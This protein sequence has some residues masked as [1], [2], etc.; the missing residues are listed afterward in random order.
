MCKAPCRCRSHRPRRAAS[1]AGSRPPR[2]R[3]HRPVCQGQHGAQGLQPLGPD[4]VAG[5]KLQPVA[6][7]FSAAKASVG[8][9]TPGQLSRPIRRVSP[10]S[11]GSH[12]RRDDDSAAGIGH[13]AQLFHGQNRACPDQGLCAKG[14]DQCRD[15][16]QRV[17]RV[18]RHLDG[19]DTC[20]DQSLGDGKRVFRGDPAQNGDDGS[21]HSAA[22][23]SGP[24]ARARPAM[25]QAV[26]GR[27]RALAPWERSAR[28]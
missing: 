11:S 27:R 2:L 25:V 15:R 17:G 16:M 14:A 5:K 23:E 9:M 4:Q 10:I 19:G 22:F 20:G 18:Q 3:P 1:P 8:V 13:F 21:G 24:A 6:P 28:A 7:A 26:A 12:V